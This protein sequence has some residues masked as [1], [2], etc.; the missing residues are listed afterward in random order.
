MFLSQCIYWSNVKNGGW[1]YKS[2][3]EWCNET[4]LTSNN[5]RTVRKGKIANYVN[6]QYDHAA[7]KLWFKVNQTAI[8]KE[9]HPLKKQPRIPYSEQLKSPEWQRKRLEAMEAAEWQCEQCECKTRQ[10][11]VHHKEYKNG[12]M[13]WEYSLSELVV[14]CEQCH[15]KIHGKE[16]K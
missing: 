15:A 12:R 11:H 4:L 2:I 14:L 16:V 13:A 5:L 1:F 6:E 3:D 8:D 10:L 9:L 7:N